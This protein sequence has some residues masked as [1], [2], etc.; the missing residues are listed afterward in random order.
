MKKLLT[1]IKNYKHIIIP[2]IVV[3]VFFGGV[4]YAQAF[5]W[6]SIDWFLGLVLSIFN[7]V[8]A[9][10]N[11]L[12]GY[13]LIGL[14]NLFVMIAQY[15]DYATSPVI[16]SGWAL[17]RDVSNM[18]IVV[19]L[20]VIAFMSAFSSK[21][22]YNLTRGL[23]MFIAAALLVNFSKMITLLAVD[24]SQ[25]I[26]LTFVNAFKE[27][28]AGNITTI[29]G[30]EAAAKVGTAVAN[31]E[32]AETQAIAIAQNIF[33]VIMLAITNAIIIGL[34]ALFLVR[35]IALWFLVVTSPIAF[36]AMA[37]P[38][39]KFGGL[40]EKWMSELG[41]WLTL[42]PMLAFVVWLSFTT[43]QEA[44]KAFTGTPAGSSEALGGL[45]APEK[46]AGFVLAIG[47]LLY[48]VKYSIE[49]SGSAGKVFG[50]VQ[51]KAL[52]AQKAVGRIVSAPISSYAK[53]AAKGVS[54]RA[55]QY[56]KTK[57]GD[58]FLGKTSRLALGGLTKR[59][60]E[61]FQ[62]R[63]EARGQVFG[64]GEASKLAYEK[65]LEKQSEG[66][67]TDFEKMGITRSRTSMVE[68]MK[69][70]IAAG[71]DQDV[72]AGFRVMADLGYDSQELW[73]EAMQEGGVLAR[74]FGKD[75]AKKHQF[76]LD[77]Q[78][79]ALKNGVLMDTT[80]KVVDDSGNVVDNVGSTRDSRISALIKKLSS[81][82]LTEFASRGDI[83]GS[84]EN[85]NTFAQRVSS[86]ASNL[87]EREI[88]Q[89][90]RGE[91]DARANQIKEMINK[92]PEYWD[93]L[94]ADQRKAHEDLYEKLTV[95][96]DG[97]GRRQEIDQLQYDSAGR[98]IMKDGKHDTKKV[99]VEGAS[100]YG[101]VVAGIV[102]AD[103]KDGK[104]W[105]DYKEG[106]GKSDFAD[107][108]PTGLQ[109]S[110]SVDGKKFGKGIPGEA[111]KEKVGEVVDALP[112]SPR[113]RARRNVVLFDLNNPA[114]RHTPTAVARLSN[115]KAD[116]LSVL[117]SSFLNE[118]TDIRDASAAG[119]G[120]L[121]TNQEVIDTLFQSAEGMRNAITRLN[122]EKDDLETEELSID[123]DLGIERA[124]DPTSKKTR[125]L[126][127]QLDRQK[128]RIKEKTKEIDSTER[129]YTRIVHE[130]I[131]TV[132]KLDN[133]AERRSSAV[134][135]VKV[136]G[137]V[138]GNV[139]EGVKGLKSQSDGNVV[140]SSVDAYIT[141]AQQALASARSKGGDKSLIQIRE[142]AL[143][144]FKSAV[145]A[146]GGEIT[147]PMLDNFQSQ[148][149]GI[150]ED[151]ETKRYF[152]N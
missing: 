53:G 1:Y 83:F 55:Y 69:K 102:K 73:D 46:L 95:E 113:I 143:D 48:G 106:L 52:S 59:G 44:S 17:V 76:A 115:F 24:V 128:K 78:K 4:E 70:A 47:M 50:K 66:R 21:S 19:G 97:D 10:V 49:V 42:G 141:M 127:D 77:I 37:V 147:T 82:Q 18:F 26:M 64:G 3:G 91:R 13:V 114:L 94:S 146:S 138:I 109:R 131:L 20:L 72:R 54:E 139:V 71:S 2:L 104:K 15:N 130:V 86:I 29:F 107:R 9:G 79:A 34:M 93:S 148:L 90:S 32:I 121:L 145:I 11:S 116:V 120:A 41:N 7:M 103:Q 92:N 45:G 98:P 43:V 25:V 27:V 89:M 126:E 87:G 5:V 74:H 123:V 151:L 105:S 152:V 58:S 136:H 117:P 144:A 16:S 65:T 63:M 67:K 150:S 57:G 133:A 51:G 75:D 60:R 12:L 39:K 134:E 110:I 118:K 88:S 100:L 125:E 6:P 85:S 96:R 137:K 84:K 119:S 142:S 40:K 28:A 23:G 108:A 61:E 68:Y 22:E 112:V 38:I 81:Q 56:S 101:N 140:R 30:I 8:I 35:V 99:K 31:G 124:I 14:I 36:A 132:G 129:D 80:D 111:E 122:T 62:E 135:V 33:G 149:E